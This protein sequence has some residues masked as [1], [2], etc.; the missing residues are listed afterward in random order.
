MNQLPELQKDASE[1]MNWSWS[2]IEPY[3]QELA[4]RELTAATVH[5]WL[6]DWSRL[7]ELLHETQQRLHVATTVNTV[8][9]EAE[10]RYKNFL[11]TIY[12]ASEAAEQKLKEKLL[13]SGLEPSGFEIQLRDMRAEAEIFREANLPLLTEERKLETEYNKVMGAQTVVWEGREVTIQQLMPV[14]QNPDRS[15]RE[16]AW[17]L[18]ASRHLADREA[19]N[20]LWQRFLRLRL[21]LARNAGFKDYRSFRWKELLRFDYTPEDCKRFHEAIEKVVVPAATRI[22]ENG[23]RRLAVITLKPWD[24]TGAQGFGQVVDPS[25]T[26]LK[27]FAHESEL[28]AKCASIFQRVDPQLGKYFAVM[29][30][31]RLLDLDNRKDKAPGGYC[32]S[33]SAVKRP[34]IFMNA[35]GLHR[36]VQTL[37]HESGHAFHV[38]EA[39]H[40]PYVQQRFARSEFSEVAS[41]GMELLA[42]P[43]LSVAHGGFYSETDA[44]RARRDH[45]EQ[46]ILFWPY[47]AAVDALQ[48]WVYENHDT[49]M[50]PAACDAQWQN[51]CERFMIGLDW[52][53]LEE[54]SKT[55]WQRQLHILTFPFYYVEYGLAQLGA[56]QVWRNALENQRNAVASYRRALALGGTVSLP[57][58]YAAAGANFTFDA[59]TLQM[60]V[61]LMEKTIDQLDAESA[62][63]KV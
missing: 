35:V 9:T 13:S 26:P 15:V 51:L 33:F 34:F 19:I 45:L 18:A 54:V 25:R 37:L 22:Y 63:M 30:N 58:L 62:Q 38:F 16:R 41:M 48:Q 29:V 21:Q 11:D 24:L 36:D 39:S 2:Q 27:P 59:D 57:D 17:R 42:A 52:T 3:Y 49:A 46:S 6:A 5:T 7:S 14:F 56:V 10:R 8:D 47:M 43:Y 23:R 1:F 44:A 60:A 20:A 4:S 55:R 31:E 53:G 12:P 32:T 28:R 61:D 50:D 40:L